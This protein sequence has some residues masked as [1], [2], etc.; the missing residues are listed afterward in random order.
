MH[1]PPLLHTLLRSKKRSSSTLISY[2]HCVSS[3]PL[4]PETQSR[5]GDAGEDRLYHFKSPHTAITDY[6][7]WIIDWCCKIQYPCP[8][9]VVHQELSEEQWLYVHVHEVY[10]TFSHTICTSRTDR[11]IQINTDHSFLGKLSVSTQSS[12][13]FP[14]K[15]NTDFGF[16]KHGGCAEGRR[17]GHKSCT[18]VDCVWGGV[19][20]WLKICTSFNTVVQEA[21]VVNRTWG[22]LCTVP[23]SLPLLWPESFASLKQWP[24]NAA[25]SEQQWF[26][27]PIQAQPALPFTTFIF[28][29]FAAAV[30]NAGT[31]TLNETTSKTTPQAATKRWTPALP[32]LKDMQV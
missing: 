2:T 29:S 13:S 31:P 4:P 32:L 30:R 1:L 6:S 19:F 15:H 26:H 25:C 21:A 11:W 3:L 28:P 9:T 23:I 17:R 16:G 24:R 27:P 10:Y 7:A 5:V 22:T 8:D 14:V 18:W 20:A 12:I